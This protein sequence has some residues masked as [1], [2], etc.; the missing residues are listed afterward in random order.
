MTTVTIQ[1][2]QTSE[3]Q[4]EA[5]LELTRA[6]ERVIQKLE[7]TPPSDISIFFGGTEIYRYQSA[8]DNIFW[9]G[10]DSN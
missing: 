2:T 4:A 5:I 10:S 8:D 6:L 3:Q 1:P 9:W 7:I